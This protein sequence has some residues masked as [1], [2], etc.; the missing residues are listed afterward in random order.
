[1]GQRSASS[2]SMHD[3]GS[4]SRPWVSVRLLT[5]LLLISIFFISS[6]FG[7]HFPYS[8]TPSAAAQTPS[9]WPMFQH[10][11]QHTSASPYIA[12]TDNSVRWIFGMGGVYRFSPVIDGDGTIYAIGSGILYS[13]NPDGS[14]R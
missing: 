2:R 7:V 13:I 1:M 6:S 10:D 12:S 14:L 3:A 4:K 11:A 8:A 5:A 9:Y